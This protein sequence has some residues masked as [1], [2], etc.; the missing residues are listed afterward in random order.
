MQFSANL[1]FLWVDRPLP[2]R[3]HAAKAA[4]FSAVECHF[5]YETP[6]EHVVA[7]LHDTGLKM[8]SLN[9]R[10]GDPAAGEF[11]LCALPGREVEARDAIIEA[12]S[13]ANAVDASAVH[14]MAGSNGDMA[15][16]R[17][18]LD[19]ACEA[20][21]ASD[22]QVLIEPLNPFDVPGYLY[23]RTDQ[24]A[25]LIADMGHANLA[26]MFDCYHVARTEGCV[27]RRFRAVKHLVGHVQFAAVPDRGAPDHGE[28]DYAILLPQLA[29][30]GWTR[31]F[32]AEYRPDGPTDDGLDWLTRL[33][34]EGGIY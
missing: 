11:G 21:A 7:A 2:D 33:G 18:A 25:A 16:F 17:R 28:V 15:V 10:P 3:I 5:P 6:T 31:P 24:A 12:V 29:A 14:V 32:G 19:F 34:P 30:E 9:T 4:G 13:Y 22:L 26:L 20:A 8:L 23:S 1:G 27:L